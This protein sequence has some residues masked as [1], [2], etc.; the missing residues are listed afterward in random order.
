MQVIMV[1]I[2]ITKDL[3]K[4]KEKLTYTFKA[5][6]NESKIVIFFVGIIIRNMYEVQ[7][8]YTLE[9]SLANN[10]SYP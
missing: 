1:V 5:Q 6:T 9:H 7:S 3:I 10:I 4:I 8:L 2:N